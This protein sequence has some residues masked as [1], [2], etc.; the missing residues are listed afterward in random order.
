[1]DPTNQQ[2]STPLLCSGADWV[3]ASAAPPPQGASFQLFLGGPNFFIFFNAT[4]LL[5]NWKKKHFIYSNLTL[6]IVPFFFFSFFLFFTLFS[7][8]FSFFFSLGGATAPS[9]L[10]WRLYPPKKIPPIFCIA[11][12]H[13]STWIDLYRGC[14]YG[15]FGMTAQKNSPTP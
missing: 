14:W 7:F 13:F 12:V 8:Y 9:P 15:A 11:L 3:G 1:M 4:G 6:F 10:K 5:K 2:P